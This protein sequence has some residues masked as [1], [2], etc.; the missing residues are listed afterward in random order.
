MHME[1][2]FAETE[3]FLATILPLRIQNQ[4]YENLKTLPMQ[5]T[6][7]LDFLE[8]TQDKFE[9]LRETIHE[10][11]QRFEQDKQK[12]YNETKVVCPRYDKRRFRE[13]VLHEQ[14]E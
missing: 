4:I 3:E 1:V 2:R 11:Q 6:D 8:N 7:K 14:I 5:R 12:P 13:P 9:D 10:I